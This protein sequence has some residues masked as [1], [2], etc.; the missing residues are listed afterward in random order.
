MLRL[1]LNREIEG[2]LLQLPGGDEPVWEQR[3]EGAT[4]CNEGRENQVPDL[5]QEWERWGKSHCNRDTVTGSGVAPTFPAEKVQKRGDGWLAHTFDF[6]KSA[7]QGCPICLERD[8][9]SRGGGGRS[10]CEFP[11]GLALPQEYGSI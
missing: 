11:L 2:A 6:M 4:N 7:A 8:G 3:G 9:W 1:R 10:R 5:C